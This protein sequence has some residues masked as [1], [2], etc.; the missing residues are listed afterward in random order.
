MKVTIK[1]NTMTIEIEI[2]KP[3][4][5]GSGKTM[6]VASETQK[7]VA[8]VNGKPLTVGINAYYKP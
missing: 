3:V 1:G 6:L 4:A 5:S 7:A 8:E 2:H